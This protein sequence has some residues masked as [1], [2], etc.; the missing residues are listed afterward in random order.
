[1]YSGLTNLVIAEQ[2]CLI[3]KNYPELNGIFQLSSEPISKYD[4]LVLAKKYFGIDVEIEKFSEYQSDKSL[5]CNKYKKATGFIAPTWDEMMRG[6][7]NDQ[8][9]KYEW[10]ND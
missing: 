8:Q 6:L 2:I 1:M 9:I 3:I 7:A 4:L 5:V 10:R